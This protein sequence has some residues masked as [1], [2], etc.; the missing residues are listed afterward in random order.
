MIIVTFKVHPFD[1]H[2][3]EWYSYIGISR[4]ESILF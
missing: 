3:G 4:K 2:M 1:K